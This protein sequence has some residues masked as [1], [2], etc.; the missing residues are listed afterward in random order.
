MKCFSPEKVCLTVYSCI[1]T[2]IYDAGTGRYSAIA[3]D[4][5]RTRNLLMIGERSNL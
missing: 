4:V 3:P 2:D 1:D 5:D